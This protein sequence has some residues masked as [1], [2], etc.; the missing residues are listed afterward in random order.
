MKG[1]ATKCKAKTIVKISFWY[2]RMFVIFR[3]LKVEIYIIYITVM[4]KHG[5]IGEFEVGLTLYCCF[6]FI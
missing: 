3:T 6:S 2:R 1:L 4:M 5:Y